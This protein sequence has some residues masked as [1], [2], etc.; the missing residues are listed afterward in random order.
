M[1]YIIWLKNFQKLAINVISTPVRR[2][3]LICLRGIK[4]T[5]FV[6]FFYNYKLLKNKLTC[7]NEKLLIFFVRNQIIASIDYYFAAPLA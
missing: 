5:I 4:N 1:T 3:L 6:N 7:T 2:K